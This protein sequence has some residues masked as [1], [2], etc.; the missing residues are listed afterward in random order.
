MVKLTLIARVSDGL[1]LA[2]GLDGDKDHELAAFKQQ[3]KVWRH[4]ATISRHPLRST[5]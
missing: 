4:I 5:P 2:E 3:A 1:P